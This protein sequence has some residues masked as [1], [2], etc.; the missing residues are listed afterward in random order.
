VEHDD[1]NGDVSRHSPLTPKVAERGIRP[2][3]GNRPKT[4]AERNQQTLRPTTVHQGTVLRQ[5][6]TDQ[7]QKRRLAPAAAPTPV[8]APDGR[9]TKKN[10]TSTVVP[11]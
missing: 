10:R 5:P 2:H 4:D 9:S 1:P 11:L 7:R 6:T 8:G 3:V